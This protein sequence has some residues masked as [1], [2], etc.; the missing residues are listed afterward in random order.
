MKPRIIAV[1]GLK[2]S[3]KDTVVNYISNCFKQYKHYK[4]SGALKTML[5]NVFDITADN[6]ENEKKDLIHPYYN[7]SPRLLMDFFGTH[8]FQYEIQKILPN[9][10]RCF[11]INKILKK[12]LDENIIISDLRFIHESNEIKKH[13]ESNLIIKVL[14]NN[15][16]DDGL[17]SEA[18]CQHIKA[19]I[20]IDNNGSM[21]ELYNKVDEQLEK[22]GLIK[23]SFDVYTDGSCF[24]NPGIGGWGV[25][26]PTINKECWGGTKCKTTNNVMELVALQRALEYIQNIDMND[27]NII[28]IY[29]D[30]KYVEQGVNLWIHKWKK[31]NWMTSSNT[32]VKNIIEWKSIDTN[33]QKLREKNNIQVSWVKAHDTNEHNNYVDKLARNF[34]FYNT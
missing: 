6:F 28:N 8:I 1:C 26:C 34:A 30:S 13:S 7:V 3:G 14:R 19:D 21:E 18:E 22:K 17:A 32:T 20:I 23:K 16:S 31:N 11:W 10:K 24:G 4:I 25:W 2:R 12:S 27:F 15:T 29:T 9:E 5:T 33:L